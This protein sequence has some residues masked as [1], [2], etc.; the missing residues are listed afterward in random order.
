MPYYRNNSARRDYGNAPVRRERALNPANWD[1]FCAAQPDVSRWIEAKAPTFDF[2]ASLK[3]AVMKFADLT[4]GQYDAVER[5]MQR[6]TARDAQRARPHQGT[7]DQ[8]PN[9]R[10]AF[11]TVVANGAIRAQITIN[12]VNLSLAPPTGKNPGAIYVKVRGD[13]K[14]KIVGAAFYPGRD[15]ATEAFAALRLIEVDPTGAVRAQAER[16]AQRLAEAAAAGIPMSLPCG[17]CGL[18]LTDPVSVARGIGPICA[19]KWGF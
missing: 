16:T 15:D 12:D 4:P 13:Y 10:A 8:F 3:N 7:Q 9:I 6:D 1:A 18:T 5:C 11:N 14:G 19:G 17:C 2:A